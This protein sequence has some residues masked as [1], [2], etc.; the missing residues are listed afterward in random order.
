MY[1]I[2]QLKRRS[3]LHMYSTL[4]FELKSGFLSSDYFNTSVFRRTISLSFSGK[5]FNKCK[6]VFCSR[7][8]RAH[9]AKGEEW[10]TKF[11]LYSLYAWLLPLTITIMT[12]LTDVYQ[13]LPHAFLPNM[14]VRYCFFYRKSA[15]SKICLSSAS[16][17]HFPPHI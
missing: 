7:A 11:L 3:S 17:V 4:Q 15:D 2:S 13:L 9:V 14:A 5:Y 12:Y 16:G 1:I 6:N 10:R 8:I